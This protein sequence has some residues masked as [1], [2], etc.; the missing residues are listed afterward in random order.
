MLGLLRHSP[1]AENEFPLA[2]RDLPLAERN[3]G[4]VQKRCTSRLPYSLAGLYFIT[5][6]FKDCIKNMAYTM[7]TFT[8]LAKNFS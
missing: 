7:V 8:I 6:I 4:K 3:A 2:E 1:L 5:L